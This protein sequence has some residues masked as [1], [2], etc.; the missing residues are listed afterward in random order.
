M[1]SFSFTSSKILKFY[2]STE[3]RSRIRLKGEYNKNIY[4]IIFFDKSQLWTFVSLNQ[5]AFHNWI[6]SNRREYNL[7]VFRELNLYMFNW[8]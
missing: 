8:K 3:S 1:I 5:M 4:E 2:E 7:P 6:T